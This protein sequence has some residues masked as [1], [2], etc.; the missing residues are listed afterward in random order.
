MG[1]LYE[2]IDSWD[3]QHMF[4][5]VV[6]FILILWLFSLKKMGINI[7]IAII[8]GICVVN[9]MNFRTIK[10]SNTLADIQKIKED[11]IDPEITEDTKEHKNI[12]DFLFSIQDMRIYS[13]RQFIESVNNINYFYDL[14]KQSFV[15]KS[16]CHMNYDLMKQYKRDAVNALQSILFSIPDDNRIRDK[17][18]S[19]A[20][21]LNDIMTTHLDEISY[22]VD[23][24]TYKHGYT[25]D[26]KIINYGPMPA[27][28]YDDLNKNYS[29]EIY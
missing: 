9:Y 13:P 28:E 3:G 20:L 6:I 27:N 7:L 8:V 26:T 23:E 17:I 18:N 22:L 24:Y 10:N 14:Y 1:E 29:Y 12:V 21:I 2:Y 16:T 15:D 5:Y 25:V 4:V 19:A 11:I